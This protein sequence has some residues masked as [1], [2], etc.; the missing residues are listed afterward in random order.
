MSLLSKYL[1]IVT[2]CDFPIYDALGAPYIMRLSPG[3][4]APAAAGMADFEKRF[5]ALAQRNTEWKINNFDVLDNLLWL[6]GKTDAGS[7]SLVL[8]KTGYKKLIG[9]LGIQQAED[10][11]RIIAAEIDARV[12][13]N[14]TGLKKILGVDLYTFLQMKKSYGL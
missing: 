1:Y 5:K 3:K 11:D 13:Q 2:G 4:I 14:D 6:C 9:Y 12:E 10:I 8:N 7:Y